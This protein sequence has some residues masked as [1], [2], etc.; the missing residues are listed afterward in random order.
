MTPAD[1]VLGPEFALDPSAEETET[2]FPLNARA[3]ET[4]ALRLAPHGLWPVTRLEILGLQFR[5]MPAS[6][7]DGWDVLRQGKAASTSASGGPDQARGVK[8]V[9][10]PGAG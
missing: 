9:P 6:W 4:A 8:A 7:Q 1:P 3:G 5:V 10:A 2:R